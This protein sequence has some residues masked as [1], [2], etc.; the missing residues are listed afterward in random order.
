MLETHM[1]FDMAGPG[2]LFFKKNKK[3]TKNKVAS[4][5]KKNGP[6]IGFF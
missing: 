5:R 2:L 3:Q 4:K 6:K 1:N